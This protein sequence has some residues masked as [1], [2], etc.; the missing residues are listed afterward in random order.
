MRGKKVVRPSEKEI[1]EAIMSKSKLSTLTTAYILKFL[2]HKSKQ[3]DMKLEKLV[4][5]KRDPKTVLE[6]FRYPFA[7]YLTAN[8]FK[9]IACL[10]EKGSSILHKDE[11]D[12]VEVYE[13]HFAFDVLKILLTNLKSLNY[14][15]IS[16]DDI[17]EES[18]YKRLKNAVG[19]FQ[20]N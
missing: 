3:L 19:K 20:D 16:L 6:V 17:M 9:S 4:T 13:V 10:L 18:D 7:S 8:T 11:L 14:C 5:E 2:S 12:Q 1:S 15:Q